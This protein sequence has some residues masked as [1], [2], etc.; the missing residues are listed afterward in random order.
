[1]EREVTLQ[2]LLEAREQRAERQR[3]WGKTYGQTLVVLTMNI[4]GPVKRTALIEEGFS[5]GS[6]ILRQRLTGSLLHW[7]EY[8][9]DTGCEGF[10]AVALPAEEVKAVTVELEE[11]HPAGRLWDMDVLKADGTKLER[12]RPRA[13]LI[14]GKPGAACARS[15]AHTVEE[16]KTETERLLRRAVMQD[17]QERAA[18][19]AV[20]ALL[21]EVCVTPKPGLVD[22]EGS[23]S[24][25]DMDL[26]RF[27]DSISVLTPYFSC[28]VQTGEETRQLP[29]EDTLKALRAPGR[30]AE[31]EMLAATGGVNTHKG[32]IFTMGILCGALGRLESSQWSCPETVLQEAA[33][34]TKGLTDRELSGLSE[35]TAKTAGQRL[36]LNYGITGIR[37]QLE[38]GLPTVLQYGL[39]ALEQALQTGCGWDEAGAAALMALIAHT[40]DTNLMKRGGVEAQKAAAKEA[41]ELLCAGPIPSGK[42]LRELDRSYREKN[43]SP[44]GCADLL[45]ACLFLHFL[46]D[47]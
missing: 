23:G 44:G 4:A 36:Y 39:P 18:A 6:R 13:C 1:M 46:W 9:Q 16:L 41:A 21:Y 20:R 26:Y 47:T 27:M 29:A 45:A 25:T 15:R 32:A 24:H 2:E 14:C 37:G 22:R 12:S 8:R 34:M 30:R 33:A 11:T 42:T 5:L 28:C 19:L 40:P 7:E 43:L 10:Y 31:M 17:R 35:E 38:E 3:Q